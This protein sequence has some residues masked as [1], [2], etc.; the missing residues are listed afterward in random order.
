MCICTF[1]HASWTGLI[2]ELIFNTEWVVINGQHME[3]GI[4]VHHWTIFWTICL[5]FII[6]FCFHCVASEMSDEQNV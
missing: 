1:H 2:I 4:V 5:H 3:I 6:F